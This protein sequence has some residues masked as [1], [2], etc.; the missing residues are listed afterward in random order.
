MHFNRCYLKEDTSNVDMARLI[1]LSIEYLKSMCVSFNL[2]CGTR[3]NMVR[4]VADSLMSL[5]EG[6]D[7]NIVLSLDLDLDDVDFDLQLSR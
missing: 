1:T 5:S 2:Q 6:V 7:Q 4:S 3:E